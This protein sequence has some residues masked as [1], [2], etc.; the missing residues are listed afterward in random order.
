VRYGSP[1]KKDLKNVHEEL[2]YRTFLFISVI[3]RLLLAWHTAGPQHGC[4]MSVVE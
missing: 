2:T 1:G 3:P 4:E